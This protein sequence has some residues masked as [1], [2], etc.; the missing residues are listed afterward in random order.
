MDT[1]N[2]KNAETTAT[3]D[4]ELLFATD[5]KGNR[6]PDED[7][8]AAGTKPIMLE[9]R[10]GGQDHKC[11]IL[12]TNV[13]IESR[14]APELWF[15]K[16]VTQQGV[17]GSEDLENDTEALAKVE[18]IERSANMHPERLLLRA[19][20]A[21]EALTIDSKGRT[22]ISIPQF[23]NGLTAQKLADDP[24]FGRR[25]INEIGAKVADFFGV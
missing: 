8:I 17:T 1:K 19:Q 20:V 24:I 14:Q 7:I 22:R 11:E 9:F 5:A 2:K 25:V 4:D 6:I 21:L 18:E 16:Y 12:M 13:S 15:R 3:E 23:Q 10:A